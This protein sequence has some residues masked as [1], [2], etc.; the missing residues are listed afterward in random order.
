MSLLVGMGG[1]HRDVPIEDLLHIKIAAGW[2]AHVC[3][4]GSR[5]GTSIWTSILAN[6]YSHHALSLREHSLCSRSGATESVYI[7]YWLRCTRDGVFAEIGGV[8]LGQA[9]RHTGELGDLLL[10]LLER[11]LLGLR[12]LLVLVLRWWTGQMSLQLLFLLLPLLLLLNHDLSLELK[13]FLLIHQLNLLL[14]QVGRI[15]MVTRDAVAACLW[16]H[17]VAGT[18]NVRVRRVGA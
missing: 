1:M 8:L 9:G 3:L 13:L 16:G 15:I 11:V 10:L 2:E 4:T 14:L 17:G 7:S 6:S 5:R 18:G 12:V